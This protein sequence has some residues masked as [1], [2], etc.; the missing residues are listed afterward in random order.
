[1]EITK[2]NR[3]F[4]DCLRGASILRVVLGH[5]G[6][7]WIYRPY[8]EF[9]HALLP[10][11][12][13]VSGAVSFGSFLRSSSVAN[14]LL[15]R[16]IGILT[17]YYVL[18]ALVYG[19]YL[20]WNGQFPPSA[21]GE[22]LWRVL[23]ITPMKADTP[24]PLGQVWY[25]HALVIITFL[26]LPF[27]HWARSS[28]GCLLLPILA[29]L[30]LTALQFV[31]DSD[32]RFVWFG[33]N[34]Y[35]AFAN[36][37]F[38]FFGALYIQTLER[39]QWQRLLPALCLALLVAMILLVRL[40]KTPVGLAHHSYA[41]DLYYVGCAYIALTLLLALRLWLIRALDGVQWL[42]R[43]LLYTSK[44]AYSIFLIHSFFIFA[45]EEWLGLMNVAQAPLL[46]LAKIALVLSASFAAAPLLT[47]LCKPV[48]KWL[49]ARFAPS[50][51][52]QAVGG[53]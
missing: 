17:P 47:H 39:W 24:F 16:L 31:V 5:L 48:S 22:S 4:L 15:R 23:F 51:K 8:S 1:L 6:L 18:I 13:F 37:S 36:A 20:G 2:S 33:H 12:F 25:L 34:F 21:S 7:F 32:H 28:I 44:H 42:K 14:Y 43:F 9:F 50:G 52:A 53:Q 30:A 11:L 29:S 45:A 49:T 3:D 10:L 27:F 35:Q 46:A 41:P 26:A 38:F 19:L 40:S